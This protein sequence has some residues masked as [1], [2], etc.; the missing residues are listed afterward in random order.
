MI[1]LPE[2]GNIEQQF[3]DEHRREFGFNLDRDI[4]VDDIRV[5]AVG[6]SVGSTTRSP[7]ADLESANLRPY[8]PSAFESKQV[9]FEGSGWIETKAVPLLSLKE[10]EQVKVSLSL[11]IL[12]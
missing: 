7:Y 4:L 6:K 8:D 12:G 10:G 11:S 1:E 2:G 3:I 9:Y 5:R